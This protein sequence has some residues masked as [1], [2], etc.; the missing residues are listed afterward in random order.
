MLVGTAGNVKVV[1]CGSARKRK[2]AGTVMIYMDNAATT[3]RK[4][5]EV[6]EAVTN[7]MQCMG[8]AGRGAH[9]ASLDASRV[10]RYERA[11][12]KA[13]WGGESKKYCIYK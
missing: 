2:Q 4:P 13:F 9:E 3:M 1:F 12:G 7:A 8:N 6:I 11:S 5:K 10:I